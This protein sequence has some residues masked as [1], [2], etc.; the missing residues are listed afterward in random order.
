MVEIGSFRY[1]CF[2]SKIYA[3]DSMMKYLD[4]VQDKIA[5]EYSLKEIKNKYI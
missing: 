1:L 5:I 2:I 3:I 4:W